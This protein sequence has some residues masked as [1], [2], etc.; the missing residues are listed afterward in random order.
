MNLHSKPHDK[1]NVGF[2]AFLLKKQPKIDIIIQ[3]FSYDSSS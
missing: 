3:G 1:K 2:S